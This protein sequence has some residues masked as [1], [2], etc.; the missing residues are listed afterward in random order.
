MTSLLAEPVETMRSVKKI[1]HIT[2]SC[3]TVLEHITT[4][5][6]HPL[7]RRVSNHFS[8]I[9]VGNHPNFVVPDHGRHPVRAAAGHANMIYI[10][11]IIVIAFILCTYA[12]PNCLRRR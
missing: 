5:V 11:D 7:A 9:T 4:L 10:I 12:D 6:A 3:N 1:G 2:P 8:R